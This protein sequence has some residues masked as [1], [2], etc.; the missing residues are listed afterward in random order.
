MKS[1]SVFENP[2]SIITYLG[3]HQLLK[4]L[5][6][7]VYIKLA[8]RF[9]MGRKLNL[10]KPTYYTEKVQWIKLYD[11]KPQ[12]TT[13]VDKYKVRDYIAS[14]IGKEYLIPLYS[15]YNSPDEI[16]ISKLPDQ[17]ILKC[18]HGS[19][20]NYICINK[21]SYNP[22]LVKTLFNKWL[23]TNWFYYGRE[24][25]Y[26][27]VPPRINCE[28]LLTNHG[29][30][31]DDYKVM[32]INGIAIGVEVHA[33]RFKGHKI[34]VYDRDWKQM[35]LMT[36]IPGTNTIIPKPAK[37]DEMISLSEQ[38]AKDSYT[39]RIDWYIV[40]NKLYFGEITLYQS[41]GYLEKGNDTIDTMMGTLL[42]LPID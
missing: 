13:Y 9:E 4:W 17:F 38:L 16:D 39:V 18:T 23:K 3:K 8:Y 22:D 20:M 34:D 35:N 41:S 10:D 32:C 33:D 6:D 21:K 26:K 29:S 1:I 40:D 5:P 7:K 31:P 12:Y 37:F 25:A 11:R 27:D 24:W 19:A 15:C 42:K 28:Q 30:I 2:R 36:N 14:T